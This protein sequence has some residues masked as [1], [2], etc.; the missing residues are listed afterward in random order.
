MEFRTLMF[1]ALKGIEGIFPT[2][3]VSL[4]YEQRGE[5]LVSISTIIKKVKQDIIQES[6]G[7]NYDTQ[8]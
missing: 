4:S 6:K 3:K 5:M 2:G 1:E 7:V 8:N